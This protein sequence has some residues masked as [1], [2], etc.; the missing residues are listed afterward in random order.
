MTKKKETINDVVKAME[1][2]NKALDRIMANED[3][4]KVIVKVK[5]KPNIVFSIPPK[6]ERKPL[7]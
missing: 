6:G 3:G 2:L 1:Y 4:G 7:R 5:G